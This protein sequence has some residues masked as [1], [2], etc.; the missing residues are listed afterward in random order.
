MQMT[1]SFL[2]AKFLTSV[3]QEAERNF[4][5]R[6]DLFFYSCLYTPYLHEP[7]RLKIESFAFVIRK[8]E[9]LSMDEIEEYVK[10]T[11]GALFHALFDPNGGEWMVDANSHD[12][13][14][15]DVEYQR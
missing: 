9:T 15:I 1:F 4:P 12:F 13:S 8:A 11:H 14:L 6:Q 3:F 2:D 10:K 5:P 7:S